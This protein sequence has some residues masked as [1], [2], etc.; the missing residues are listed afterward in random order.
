MHSLRFTLLADFTVISI[1]IVSC[2][3]MYIYR[4]HFKLHGDI[5][6]N[7]VYVK[8]ICVIYLHI[9]V[10]ILTIANYICPSSVLR[11]Q[12]PLLLTWLNFNHSMDK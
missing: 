7:L 11:H 12:G 4:Y 3:N 6:I 8:D 9:G 5:C 10:P 2:L 1:C